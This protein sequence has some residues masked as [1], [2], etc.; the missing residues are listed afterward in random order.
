MVVMS[1]WQP[2][3]TAPKD[4]WPNTLLLYWPN[5]S[6]DYFD[7]EEQKECQYYAPYPLIDIGWWGGCRGADCWV[8]TP[9]VDCYG[10][11]QPKHAPTHWMPLPEPPS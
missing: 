10:L 2:I 1:A 11:A 5:Y 3:E 8:N 9:E 4:G 6:Y 7:D